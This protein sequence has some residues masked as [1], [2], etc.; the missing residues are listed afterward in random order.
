VI[1]GELSER[2]DRLRRDRVPFV[3]AT[4]VRAQRPTSA[5]VGDTAVI[6]PDS[7]I[8]GFVGGVC[9][10]STV[11]LYA[12][13]ALERGE[14][15]FLRIVPGGTGADEEADEAG[16][17]VVA[18][19]PCLSG[20]TI[21]LLLEPQLPEPHMII[22]GD[23]PIARALEALARDSGYDVLRADSPEIGP[24][25]DAV[26]VASHGQNEEPVLSSALGAGV[27]YVA[28]VCSD[29]RGAAVRASLDLADE[30]RSKLHAPAGLPIGAQSPAE[31]AI[32]I[33]AEIVAERRAH[34]AE[35]GERDGVTAPEALA[36]PGTAVDPVCGMEVVVSD[37]TLHVDIEGERVYFCR[38]QCRSTY[39]ERR[40]ADA[41]A[42][43]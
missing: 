26:I 9:A 18:H 10:E 32:A 12:A 25:A 43:A 22:V 28:L 40:A 11:R 20:G 16:E 38:E 14:P 6:L 24:D 31:V 23:A 30:L 41:T 36:R 27:G 42:P 34:P 37:A 33:L 8:E 1:T 3:F 21:E 15:L 29:V 35:G 39:L 4:V 19:N 2:A 7:T 17:T 13:K 5:R